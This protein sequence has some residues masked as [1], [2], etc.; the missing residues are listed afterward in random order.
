MPNNS[1]WSKHTVE[2]VIAQ[3]I[4]I[5]VL[6]KRKKEAPYN[7]IQYVL[8]LVPN[9]LVQRSIVLNMSLVLN[10]QYLI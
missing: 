9:Q 6:K 4:K 8:D 10:E 2:T 7:I 3:N 5:L 1:L